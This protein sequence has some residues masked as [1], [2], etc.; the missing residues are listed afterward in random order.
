MVGLGK[1]AKL[2]AP[3]SAPARTRQRAGDGRRSAAP[4]PTVPPRGW[5]GA[6]PAAQRRARVPPGGYRCR[7]ISRTF[8][9]TRSLSVFAAPIPRGALPDLV[10]NV[11]SGT[12]APSQLTAP[13]VCLSTALLVTRVVQQRRC[14]PASRSQDPRNP[15]LAE[16]RMRATSGR[17]KDRRALSARTWANHSGVS[18]AFGVP[19]WLAKCLVVKSLACRSP[20]WPCLWAYLPASSPSSSPPC[21]STVRSRTGQ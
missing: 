7:R 10:G 11:L 16:R 2:G 17:D 12:G 4:A 20:S 15:L 14:L 3:G 6:G 9:V 8:L 1:R 5:P 18:P 13:S 21:T 19:S